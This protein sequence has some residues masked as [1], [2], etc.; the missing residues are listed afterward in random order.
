M[1]KPKPLADHL[2]KYLIPVYE[3]K[4]KS[5]IA[6]D[7]RRFTSYTDSL[8]IIEANSQRQVTSIAE[9][10]IKHLKEQK[11]SAVGSE[12][13]KEGE[14]ALLDYGDVI[15]HVFESR[16]KAYYNLEGLWADAPR[17]DLLG[18]ETEPLEDDDED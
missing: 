16:I 15:I 9:H 5:I 8:I 4:A 17:I 10:I 2:Q 6:I 18:F 13:V 11:I 3:R 12:G 7:V 14:W 1:T